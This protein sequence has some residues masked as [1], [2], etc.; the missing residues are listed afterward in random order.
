M[1]TKIK[2]GMKSSEGYSLCRLDH[3]RIQ[4]QRGDRTLTLFAEPGF[5]KVWYSFWRF[6][7]TIIYFS[8]VRFW[9]APHENETISEVECQFIKKHIRDG[10]RFLGGRCLFDEDDRSPLNFKIREGYMGSSKGYSIR[11]LARDRLQYQSGDKMLT[12]AVEETASSVGSQNRPIKE[13][14]RGFMNMRK[15]QK[16]VLSVY[17]SKVRA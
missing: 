11:R 2:G 16:N 13:V 14:L 15:A 8:T 3:T 4:Y 5:Q 12:V 7:V 6:P 9:D 10:L 1:K 17:L